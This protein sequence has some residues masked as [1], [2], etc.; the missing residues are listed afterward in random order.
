[1]SIQEL[2][3]LTVVTVAQECLFVQGNTH[4]D[5]LEMRMFVDQQERGTQAMYKSGKRMMG[6]DLECAIDGRSVESGPLK[7]QARISVH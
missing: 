2:C 4:F 3:Q 1:M 7:D 6:Q 5:D